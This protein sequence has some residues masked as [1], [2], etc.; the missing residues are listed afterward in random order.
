[1]A[2]PRSHSAMRQEAEKVLSSVCK[3]DAPQ[4]LL[5]LDKHP[6]LTVFGYDGGGF[7]VLSDD[8]RHPALLGYSS[9]P[10]RADSPNEGF[11]WWLQAMATVLCHDTLP[12]ATSPS[13]VKKS[14]KSVAPLLTTSWGQSFPYNSLCPSLCPTGC[15]TTATCQVLKYFSWPQ[16]GSGTAFTYFPFGD[17][18]DGVRLEA[19]LDD[20]EY[21]Y[22][23]MDDSYRRFTTEA[24][25]Q[26]VAQLMYHVGLSAKSIYDRS[27]TGAYSETLCH[28]L[29]TNLGYPNAVVI[30]RDDYTSEEWMDIIYSQLGAGIP[31][32]YGGADRT[33]SGHEFVL[34]GY[35]TNGAVHI[36]WGW[37]GD[38][39][40]FFRL[41]ELRVS[42]SYDFSLYQDMVVGCS[43]AQNHAPHAT[44]ELTA[45]GTL[46]SLLPAAERD[47][48]VNL[49]VKGPIN[50]S[51]LKLL[52]TMAGCDVKGHGTLGHLSRL[53]LSDATIVSGGEAY[54]TDDGD[55]LFTHDDEMPWKAF[56]RCAF[57]IEVQLPRNLKTY[58]GA[59]F[60]DCSNLERVE[61]VATSDATF[62]FD[63]G[64]V[65]SSDRRHLIEYL[66]DGSGATE[67]YVPEGVISIGDYAFAGRFLYEW[68]WLPSTIER[69]G[70]YA[71]NRCYNLSRT[72]IVASEPPVTEPSAIDDLDISL[73][74]LYVP[75]GSLRR[76]RTSAGWG[77]YFLSIKESD[78]TESIETAVRSNPSS[79]GNRIF[80]LW[81]RNV[82]SAAEASSSLSPG[83]YVIAG[84]KVIVR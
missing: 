55:A 44:I 31:L 67:Y 83:L 76:Y 79:S 75:K 37:D 33:Y 13:S 26:S 6:G 52:R 78:F 65:L 49:T 24:Q 11:R 36:N 27:G 81:G 69:I 41:E 72:Y 23:L 73:R 42:H 50:G 5:Q 32:I 16:W 59:V 54:L 29:R 35:D 57:L 48:I 63:Q 68:M 34:D 71:F 84:R 61:L 39:D 38:M 12:L 7:A 3:K 51:D 46:S 58:A 66:P 2:R 28:G 9:T 18:T 77:K 22:D 15:V 64:Y 10:Y 80:D 19:T 82:G 70:K 4:A 47:T 45:A 14:P 53:D 30:K 62:V 56:A 21:R 43:P 17:H 25:K 74:T 1:M 40:G 60:A 20:V 8:D